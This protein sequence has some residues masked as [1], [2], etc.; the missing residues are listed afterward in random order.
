MKCCGRARRSLKPL[1]LNAKPSE[2]GVGRLAPTSILHGA[3]AINSMRR[4]PLCSFALDNDAFLHACCED[5]R[6]L[7]HC[8][9]S[10][11]L[12]RRYP[13]ES[14]KTCQ[15]AMLHGCCEATVDGTTARYWLS[16][17]Y[18]CTTSV[19]L[20]SFALSSSRPVGNL[21][22]FLRRLLLTSSMRILTTTSEQLL[23]GLQ[24]NSIG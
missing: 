13:D 18:K 14:H 24:H 5:K 17:S 3:V 6:V 22:R 19:A 8:Y 9:P 23:V 15:P 1:H 11:V 21:A 4:A 7:G 12:S 16:S 2:A 20:L 10:P